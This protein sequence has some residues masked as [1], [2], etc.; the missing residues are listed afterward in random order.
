MNTQELAQ[1]VR[2]IILSNRYLTMAT[3]DGKN[4]WIAPLAYAVEPNYSFIYYSAVDSLHSKHIAKNPI[5]ACAIFDSHASSDDADGIQF[6]GVVSEVKPQELEVIMK[7]YF[8]QSFPDENIRKRW[9]RPADD[10]KAKAI[11]RFYRIK[12]KEIYTLD[13]T[14]PKVDRRVLV[15][16][17]ELEKVPPK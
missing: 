14:N 12:S 2:R 7:L 11:Q 5:V 10:F 1:R 17:N 3:T 16:L 13:L 4:P 9:M 15:D 8:E 6:S